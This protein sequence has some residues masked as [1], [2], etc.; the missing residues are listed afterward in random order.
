MC[1]ACAAECEMF[2]DDE[3]MKRCAK[4]CRACAKACREFAKAAA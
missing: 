3:A 2:G 1:D 4:I